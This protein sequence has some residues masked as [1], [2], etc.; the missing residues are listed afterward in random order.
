MTEASAVEVSRRVATT[1]ETVFPYFTDPARHVQWMGNDATL[2]PAP[3]G[4][5]R[6][7]M[8]DGFGVDGE[9]LEIEPPHRVVVAWGW[10]P[11]SGKT[12][13]TGPQPDDA[14]PAGSTRVAVTVEPDDGG[15][16][17]TLR[18]LDLP[19]TMLEGHRVAWNVYLDRLG[20]CLAGGDPGPDSHA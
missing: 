18:H 14:V 1:P 4:A 12:A 13:K 2:E 11:G 16:R 6:L 5:Y 10:A 17:V 20:V 9:Y 7:R 8:G 3:G 15:S 19:E